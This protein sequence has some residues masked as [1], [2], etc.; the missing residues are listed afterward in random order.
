M[1]TETKEVYYNIYCPAC[2]HY[3]KGEEEDP[4]HDC[5]NQ[6]WN[7]NSH[8]PIRFDA[9]EGYDSAMPLSAQ[10]AL[11]EGMQAGLGKY[12]SRVSNEKRKP[13]KA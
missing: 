4:C 5:L 11:K 8:K 2:M 12:A 10:E 7:Y 3:E 13:K 6:G 1:D 9:A